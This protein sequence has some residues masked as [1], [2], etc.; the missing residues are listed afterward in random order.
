[1]KDV[2]TEVNNLSNLA[3][4]L[5]ISHKISFTIS[6]STR[7][8]SEVRYFEDCYSLHED[9]KTELIFRDALK[10]TTVFG[11]NRHH[12]A[13]AIKKI[14]DRIPE[15]T[16]ER[17]VFGVCGQYG[18]LGMLYSL[19]YLSS[20]EDKF[21]ELYIAKFFDI[22]DYISQEMGLNSA[23]PTDDFVLESAIFKEEYG[24]VLE[25]IKR[26][27]RLPAAGVADLSDVNDTKSLYQRWLL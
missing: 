14:E 24:R 19:E 11:E 16:E 25:L 21:M 27:P 7:F 12:A 9:S 15:L 13:F 17:G 5:E 3:L 10:R 2:Y 6:F 4:K 26:G 18:Y 23:S 22:V 20:G 1:M 8:I